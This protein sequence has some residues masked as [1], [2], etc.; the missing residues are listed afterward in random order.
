MAMMPPAMM[1]MCQ[2]SGMVL[3]PAVEVQDGLAVGCVDAVLDSPGLPEL[4]VEVDQLMGEV[5]CLEIVN[6][7]VDVVADDFLGA[8][9]LLL[10]SLSL[11]TMPLP[12]PPAAGVWGIYSLI[13]GSSSLLAGRTFPE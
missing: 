6:P 7:C 4:V 9:V 10:T 5:R 2:R 13:G 12:L 1:A 8:L 3:E 11:A